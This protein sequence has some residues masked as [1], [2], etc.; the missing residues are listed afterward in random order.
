MGHTW[1][2]GS[3]DGVWTGLTAI[4]L[5]PGGVITRESLEN[6]IPTNTNQ[7]KESIMDIKLRLDRALSADQ[8]RRVRE[9]FEKA[10]KGEDANWPLNGVV[11]YVNGRG[12]KVTNGYWNWDG[13]ETLSIGMNNSNQRATNPMQPNQ[14]LAVLTALINL[15]GFAQDPTVIGW[16]T[17][18]TGRMLVGMYRDVLGVLVEPGD[19]AVTVGEL[20]FS[21]NGVVAKIAGEWRNMA[22]E[23]V[24]P[25]G[26]DWVMVNL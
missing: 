18:A 12:A 21:P 6:L 9:F 15:T 4:P 26:D 11:L 19:S 2:N 3:G 1:S 20:A 8:Q 7:R 10:L 5:S 16:V 25:T 17:E 22:G 14:K 24:S 13:S 23:Q